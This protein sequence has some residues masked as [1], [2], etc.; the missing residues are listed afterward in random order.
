M[1]LWYTH[2]VL[3]MCPRIF[4]LE[5]IFTIFIS[6]FVFWLVPHFPEKT[7]IL[8]PTDKAHLL[9]KLKMDKG[10]QKLSLKSVNWVKVLTDY[11][12]WFP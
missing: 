10:D 3:T 6:F 2:K 1:S 8:N 7:K 11:R 9:H 12:I 4:I 5:G